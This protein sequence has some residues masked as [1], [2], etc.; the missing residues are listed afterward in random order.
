MADRKSVWSMIAVPAAI[1]LAIT[2]LRLVGE[3]EHWPTPWFNNAAG[4]GAAVVGIS[5]LPIFFGPWFALKLVR[6]GEA[7]SSVGKAIGFAILSV[8]VLVGAGFW[9]GKLSQNLTNLLLVPFAL[10]LVTAFIPGFGWPSL[11]K[12][13]LAYSLAARVPVL[14]V[15]YV[16]MSAN[17]GQGWGTHYDVIDPRLASFSFMRKYLY[18]AFVPQMTLWIGWTVAVGALFGS[19]AAAVA[20]LGKR[21]APAGA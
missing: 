10:M 12:T 20:R 5:W 21:P 7:P 19:V 6:T 17:G 9:A 2:V 11:G 1:T 18:E 4:G 8:V 14:V 13:L 3:L 15:M 16:A